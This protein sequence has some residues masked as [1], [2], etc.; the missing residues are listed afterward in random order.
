MFYHIWHEDSKSTAT[1]K[2]A[3]TIFWETLLSY[4][5]ISKC[6]SVQGFGGN[7]KLY[8]FMCNFDFDKDSA[9]HKYII[10][11][12]CVLDNSNAYAY[13]T[14]AKQ[15]VDGKQNVYFAD[16]VCFE[17]LLL[18][19]V[20]FESWVAPVKTKTPVYANLLKVREAL[21][22]CIHTGVSWIT[23]NTVRTF[24]LKNSNVDLNDVNKCV[25]VLQHT[26]SEQVIT[27][28]LS[29]LTNGIPSDF[30][31]AK[32]NIGA[33]WFC[34]CTP[35]IETRCKLNSRCPKKTTKEK[36]RNLWNSTHAKKYIHNINSNVMI[37]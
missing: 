5:N 27:I 18:D 19:F 33:C 2:A 6:F 36:I 31:V 1:I 9:Q 22:E 15:I 37:M 23:D 25:D 7:S 29:R 17:Y 30:R 3:T 16:L 14:K 12:D 8:E 32:T 35:C 13:Y 10:F 21:L 4:S 24:V 28:L 20:P 34:D 11:M 26:T